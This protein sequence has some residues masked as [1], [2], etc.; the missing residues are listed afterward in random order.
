[1]VSSLPAVA[2]VTRITLY[3]LALV[4]VG[5]ERQAPPAPPAA[6]TVLAD[7]PGLCHDL[8]TFRHAALAAATPVELAVLARWQPPKPV[9]AADRHI[10]E[11]LARQYLAHCG[12]AEVVSLAQKLIAFPTV[13][14]AKNAAKG[15]AFA[16]LATFLRGWAQDAGLDFSVSGDNDVWELTL[17]QG[18]RQLDLVTH[19]D[20]VPEGPGWQHPAFVGTVAD[21]RLWGRGS[22]DDKGPT[23]AVLTVL[24]TL[25]AMGLTPAWRIV[26]V[27]G[28]AEE[29]DWSGMQRY[30]KDTPQAHHT[31]SIDAAFPVV[32][33]ES[34]FVTWRLTAPLRGATAQP[35]KPVVERLNA[36]AFVTQ[37]PGEAD[38]WLRPGTAQNGASL[39]AAVHTAAHSLAQTQ[40]AP[41]EA[42]LRYEVTEERGE[43]DGAEL[44]HVKVLGKAV[45]ASVPERGQNA[46]VGLARLATALDV[47]PN[48]AGSLLRAV[49]QFFAGDLEGAK[50]GLA[51]NDAFMGKLIVVPTL[52]KTAGDACDLAINMRRPRGMG[53]SEFKARL[54]AALQ[55][56][57]S[58]VDRRIVEREPP[59]VGE[60]FISA[61][62]P[63][64]V[65]KLLTLYRDATGRPDAQSVAI[66]GGTY[67][68]LFPEAVSFGPMLPD[69]PVTAHGAEE[70]IEIADLALL[71]RLLFDA[72]VALGR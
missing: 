22:E 18:P 26:A 3:G 46:L 11:N 16:D 49:E 33:A 60:P 53:A 64:L 42:P 45:H 35:H 8:V 50:L 68:R 7:D 43:T 72:T 66:R 51:Y 20:V 12:P 44:V 52:L 1:M 67:A 28:T 56:L 17:G 36:G 63:L 10:I 59:Y 62:K 9:P 32:V 48:G 39:S 29:D 65:N 5:C 40:A 19:V 54:R 57:Q 47:A 38:M 61:A 14:G 69:R 23:A 55:I 37:V 4:A 13:D 6:S 70:S 30:V 25:S 71:T 15:Q 2:R 31:L 41:V 21:G 34:G 27:L 24:R 58:R